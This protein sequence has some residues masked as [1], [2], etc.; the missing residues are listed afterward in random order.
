MAEFTQQLINGIAQ[1][2]VYALIG[3]GV[4][5]VFG[6][7]R[8][9]NFAHGEFLAIGAMTLWALTGDGLGFW[10]NM[11][12]AVFLTAFIAALVFR[13]VFFPTLKE[14]LNG[15]I[16]SLGLITIDQAVLSN[17]VGVNPRTVNG[18]VG[19]VLSVSGIII[20]WDMVM[21]IA[22]TIA[23]AAGIIFAMDHSQLGRRVRATSE[24]RYA[25]SLMGIRVQSII[26]LVFVTG[27]A[28]AALAGAFVVTVFAITPY[29][30]ITFVIYGFIVAI[31][32]G[33]GH[34][35]G[36]VI[37]GFGLGVIQT[38]SGAY[39]SLEFGGSVAYILLVLMLAI[40]P[41]GLYR[42]SSA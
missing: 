30:G 7:T 21:I 39:I 9:I 2:S 1:G 27:S 4:T 3:I 18:P 35:K 28:L 13:F 40:R 37:A 11:L 41:T 33:L 31:L 15:F 6:L 38:L 36:A 25:A 42:T 26:V 29:S 23:L 8:L 17:L 5:L 34:P 20:P 12:L 10:I 16:V 24:D 32:G 19:G 22:V 14:P